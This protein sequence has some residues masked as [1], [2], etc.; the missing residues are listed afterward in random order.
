MN[1]SNPY[2]VVVYYILIEGMIGLVHQD[3]FPMVNILVCMI[4][5]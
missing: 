5:H 2:E 4:I 1:L 3:N